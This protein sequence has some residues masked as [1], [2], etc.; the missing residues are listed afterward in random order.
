MEA[1]TIGAMSKNIDRLLF[2]RSVAMIGASPS[3]DTINGIVFANLATFPGP[4][5]AVNPRYKEVLGRPC[6]PRVEDLPEAVDLG[7]IMIPAEEAVAAVDACGRRGIPAVIVISAGFREMGE[8]GAAREKELV[9]VAQHHGILMLGPN[10][11]GVVS[12]RV[13]LNTT[14]APRGALPGRIAFLTQSG[15]FGSAVLDRAWQEK[16]GLSVFVA[17]GNKALLDESDFL[18]PLAEDPETKVIACYLEG[19]ADGPR[20]LRLAREVTRIKPVVVLKAGRSQAGQRATLSHTGTLA[21]EARAYEAAFRQAGIIPARNVEELFDFAYILAHQPQPRGRKLAI[22]S[23]AGGPGVLAADTAEEAGLRVEPFSP[24]TEK[25]LLE[26][27]PSMASAQ[28]PVDMLGDATAARY[29][30]TLDLV[31]ADPQVDMAVALS[32]PHPIL[33]YA[34]LARIVVQ[35]FARHG[36][37]MAVSF[38]AGDLGEEAR[39]VLRRAGIPSLFDPSRA[40]RAL[41]VLAHYAEVQHRPPEEP[42]PIACDRDAAFRM[43]RQAKG[44]KV[45]G[46]EAMD[47]LAAYGLPVARGT[48]VHTPEEAAAWADELGAP[49]ALKLVSP[50]VVHKTEVGGVRL[51]V[52]PHQVEEQAQAMLAAFRARFPQA[53]VE[54]LY[55]QEMLPPGRE[56][57]LGALRDPIFG[58]MVLFGLGGIHVEVLRDVAWAV[59]P[60]SPREAKELVRSIRAFPIL[61]GVRGEPGVDLDALAQA[62]ERLSWLVH[63]FPEIA[64]LDINPVL[65]YPTGVKAVDLRIRVKG[66]G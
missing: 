42:R 54:G 33:T 25:A 16:L 24:A 40:V 49:V 31:L 38:M 48:L 58:P 32:A 15:A 28:N 29:A 50:A 3:R 59:A 47:L 20:F 36:K 53:P 45:L 41:A 46:P 43:L 27:L 21:G 1:S 17:L 37:P 61:E 60:V 14:F 65:A 10:T 35:A 7:V 4:V 51:H 8:E 9:A 6:F 57:I 44:K 62:V 66:D 18:E 39:D 12:P 55:V 26:R 30:E 11:F 63:D 22:V 19:V 34:E 52:P 64:E 5:Y 2:P 13:G 23:N 56:V